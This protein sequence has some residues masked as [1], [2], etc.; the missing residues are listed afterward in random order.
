MSASQAV[1]YHKITRK[2]YKIPVTEALRNGFHRARRRQIAPDMLH[3]CPRL[4]FVDV[5]TTG[6]SPVSARVTEVA[7]IVVQWPVD[8]IGPPAL[9]RWSS[10]VNPGE[11]IPSEISFLTG[12]TNHLVA[13]APSFAALAP[14]IGQLLENAVFVAHHARFDYGF[15]KA[16]MARAGIRF[17]ART[18]CT[19][20]LSRRLNPDRSPH[21]LDALIIRHQLPCE[22]RHR[23]MGDAQVLWHFLNRMWQEHGLDSVNDAVRKLLQRPNLPSHLGIES[24]EQ[25]PARPGIYFFHGLNTHP[26]YIGKSRNIRQR[27]ASH[28]CQDHT[29]ERGI[30]LASET[31]RVTWHETAGEF[32]ALL[33]EIHA[34]QTQMPAH[35]RALRAGQHP[36]AI[37]FD[38]QDPSPRFVRLTGPACLAPAPVVTDDTGSSGPA[39]KTKRRSTMPAEPNAG[40]GDLYGPFSSRAA[41]RSH[42]QSL[43][44]AHHLCQNRL[45]LARGTP[46]TPCFAHQLGRC[47]GACIGTVTDTELHADLMIALDG[48]QIPSW[49]DTPLL[50][51]ESSAHARQWHL[52]DRW[53]WVAGGDGAPPQDWWLT[54]CA[55]RA[56]DS[57]PSPDPAGLARNEAPRAGG[58]RLGNGF[59]RAIYQLIRKHFAQLPMDDSGAS[60]VS[61]THWY[62]AG[63]RPLS[64]QHTLRARWLH[65]SPL[66]ATSMSDAA[67]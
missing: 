60:Q 37:R 52:F 19:V 38:P 62:S 33:A 15:I 35:N 61:A 30:R 3:N 18:L 21:S 51:T 24:V 4:A 34:I 5:E 59:S 7:I 48:L 55:H 50:I 26:L 49:P 41:A 45:G 28:F 63:T 56:R 39:K 67:A 57:R 53:C 2:L 17:Q 64:R 54:S 10:L 43:A 42:L 6:G 1:L 14:T 22:T 13:D 66:T 29:S 16:E 25:I 44:T 31:R 46:G 40:A 65:Q 8:G 27:I 23:A 20:R 32:S 11:P 36:V 47:T 9:E 12:I 58:V